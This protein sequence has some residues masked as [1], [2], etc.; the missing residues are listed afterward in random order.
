MK[1]KR[2]MTIQDISCV[3]RCS[4]TVALPIISA[5]GIETSIIPTAVLSTHTGGFE[6]Y[7]Y[8]DLTDQIVPITKH[9]EALGLTFDA[10]YTGY[11]GSFEQLDIVSG[12]F[13]KFK[14]E[15]N[16]ILVDPAMADGGQ[17][18][19]GFSTEFPKGMAGLC[20]KADMI[21]P[22]ITEAALMLDEEYIDEGYDEQY[23]EKLLK[24][25]FALGPSGII[26]TGVSLEKGKLGIASYDGEEIKYYFNN[27]TSGYFHGTGD[28]YA[29]TFLAAYMKTN[30]LHKAAIIATDFTVKCIEATDAVGSERRYGVNFELCIP[31][32]LIGLGK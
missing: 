9:W 31:D 24:G 32:L 7:T 12:I 19:G 8:K 6:N 30:D 23:I 10:I 18:Y 28:V 20:A 25:L 26:L 21:V 4:L 15:D 14:R 17:L 16:F 22:N 27:K 11:L 1:Q 29:S 13:S 3:G 5:A 2:I